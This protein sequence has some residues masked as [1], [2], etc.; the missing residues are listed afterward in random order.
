MPKNFTINNTLNSSN[1][2]FGHMSLI[3]LLLHHFLKLDNVEISAVRWLEQ[4][5]N[6]VCLLSSKHK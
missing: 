6:Q 3:E 1:L 2:P 4:N 5:T